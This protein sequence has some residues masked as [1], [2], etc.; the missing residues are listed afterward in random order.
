[1]AKTPWVAPLSRPSVFD[2]RYEVLQNL[3]P[4]VAGLFG[5]ELDAEDVAAF[6][7][8]GERLCVRGLGDAIGRDRRGIRMR[9]IH[10]GAGRNACEQT[11]RREAVLARRIRRLRW[12]EAVPA[13][14]RDLQP[15]VLVALE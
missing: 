1:M 3:Q 13:D 11:R 4:D 10:L 9:E 6:D 2:T 8:G 5:V 14:V 7:C 15:C 12:F